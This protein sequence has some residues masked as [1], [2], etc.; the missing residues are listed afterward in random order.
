ML[1]L[2]K[3]RYVK[4]NFLLF[5]C[6]AAISS[7]TT[8]Y[9]GKLPA[10]HKP[11]VQLK[12]GTTV[13][14]QE[15]GQEEFGKGRIVADTFSYRA[16]D[17]AFY[18]N[19]N[20]IFANIKGSFLPKVA[21]G[22]INVYSTTNAEHYGYGNPAYGSP[23]KII[24]YSGDNVTPLGFTNHTYG[25][26]LY[27]QGGKSQDIVEL[28]YH[29]LK[30]MIPANTP[31]GLMLHNFKVTRTVLRLSFLAGVACFVGGSNIAGTAVLKNESDQKIASG[32]RLVAGG[33]CIM[34]AA[35]I[36]LFTNKT[37]MKRAIG[38]YNGKSRN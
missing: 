33:M 18:G 3:T 35:P 31:A 38:I 29:N 27:V 11:Y 5:V 15:V 21:E 30:R 9:M 22:K 8:P 10:N 36:A 25:A 24:V 26:L 2:A 16:K 34:A 32:L 6:L 28:K 20:Q 17:V 12:N 1:K 4:K 7:C 14:A 37:K 19:G 23:G 13:Y